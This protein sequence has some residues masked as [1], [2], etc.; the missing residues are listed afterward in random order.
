MV[1]RVLCNSAYWHFPSPDAALNEVARV[2]D[3]TTG[4]FLFNI[5]DQEFEFGDGAISEMAQVAASLFEPSAV[6]DGGMRPELSY[7]RIH[8]LASGN[9]FGVADFSILD[10]PLCREDLMRFYSIPHVSARRFPELPEDR[11][12]IAVTDAFESLDVDFGI[13]YRWAQFILEKM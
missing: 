4:Q 5:P 8:R 3:P 6:H 12:T 1:D 11:R 7:H 2:L 10:I 13:T 9:G